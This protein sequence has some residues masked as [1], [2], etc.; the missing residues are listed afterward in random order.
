[1]PQGA[2]LT[3][4]GLSKIASATPLDQL[5]VVQIAVGD[6]NGG[7]PTLTPDMTGLVNEVWRGPASN[8]IRDPNNA[9]IL[10]FEA[11]IPALAGPFSIREQA[12][13]D[14]EGDMI[15]IGQTSLVEKPDPSSAV[16]VVATMRLHVALSNASQ[17]DLFYTD[18]A[19]TNH[20]S[21]T[22]RDE[23]RSHPASA[24]TGISEMRNEII[25]GDIFPS[26]PEE[27]AKNGDTVTAGTTHLRILVG[28]E[29]SL[30]EMQ[31]KA[32]GVVSNLTEFTATIGVD[33]VFFTPAISKSASISIFDAGETIDPFGLIPSDVGINNFIQRLKSQ[34]IGEDAHGAAI[35]FPRGDFLLD[36]PIILPK[37][38]T[39]PRYIINIVGQGLLQTRFIQS[40]IFPQGRAAFEWEGGN[41][42]VNF[43][44]LRGFT[45]KLANT[46]GVK[47][48]HYDQPLK[49]TL[50]EILDNTFRNF[51]MKDIYVLGSCEYHSELIKLE[52][53]VKYGKV[54]NITA[55]CTPVNWA[56]D[57]IILSFDYNEFPNDDGSGIHYSSISNIYGA[58]RRGG[59]HQILKG[60]L[61]R[62]DLQTLHNTNGNRGSVSY[63]F[64]NSD[65]VTGSE[66]INEGKGGK[67][68]TFTN[69][70]G[71][72]VNGIGFGTP[73]DQ[74]SGFGNA[75]E[76][77]ACRN[78][79]IKGQS[80]R[81]G[82]PTF[83]S[84]GVKMMI[85]DA[86]CHAINFSDFDVN[87]S[88]S[89]EVQID[90][91]HNNGCGGTAYNISSDR[92]ESIGSI[93]LPDIITPSINK[94]TFKF[95]SNGATSI[96]ASVNDNHIINDTSP[97]TISNIENGNVGQT[98]TLLFRTG[99]TTI[100]EAGNIRIQGSPVLINQFSVI[101]FLFDGTNWYAKQVR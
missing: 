21:L 81:S 23:A 77:T 75:V 44:E 25:A 65:N 62:C 10:I 43:Q 29:S 37:S 33:E 46:T 56:K 84:L 90:A 42:P 70:R 61:H 79:N 3:N 12:I 48:I 5:N 58:L 1:M 99:N 66:W 94:G 95:K 91:P 72:E 63:E 69:C 78:F 100:N 89:S 11:Q 38:S 83:S 13:F 9:N 73:S 40:D 80:R 34:T 30:V 57:P 51:I 28:G 45:V 2:I 32:S 64:I 27:I 92:V 60:R 82:N 31:P 47:A 18:T 98:V 35:E 8:P 101:D 16:G 54:D 76:F 20:N 88:L 50:Q 87:T 55:D 15:A 22:N 49:S 17:V 71:F 4:V 74:G 6:G 14:D 41:G 39:I 86:D 36:N 93:V 24:I 52:G 19:A 7:Y 67:Q 97:T 85:I 59:Y 26:N 96:D 53:N 68:Y